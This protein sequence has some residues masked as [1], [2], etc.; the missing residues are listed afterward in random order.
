MKNKF[1]EAFLQGITES[2]LKNKSVYG[3]ILCVESGDSSLSLSSAAGN[4]STQDHYFIASVTK[5]Y[6]TATLLILRAQ[7]K[8]S[9]ADKMHSYFPKELINGIHVLDGV[10]YT[11]DITIAHLLSNTSGIPDYFYYDKAKGDAVAILLQ[12]ND[13]AWPLEKAVQRAKAIKPKFK[14]GQKGKVH[15]SDTNYQLLGG[16]IEKVTGQWIGD[17]FKEYIFDPLGLAS[18][19]A[20]HG[21]DDATPAPL[22]Y[23]SKQVHA[24]KYMTSITAEGGL[25]STARDTM[26]FLKAFFGGFF[27]PQETLEELKQNWNMILFPGQFF[28]GLGIEKLWTPWLLSPLKPIGEVLGFWGQSGAFAFY[29]PQTD[30]YFTGTVNQLSGMGHSAAYH[31]IMK[32]IKSA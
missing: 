4:L 26:A 10:D 21:I 18:T 9:F 1:N 27:F 8:L 20:F 32:I 2:M 30:L 14:P 3:A 5:L 11:E 28:F 19:Y 22:Y 16:I 29:N 17:V 15:Y 25:V 24:P 12:G 13:E 6:I 23:K 31:A 7:G